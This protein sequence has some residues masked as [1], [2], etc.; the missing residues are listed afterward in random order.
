[1]KLNMKIC[2]SAYKVVSAKLHYSCLAE[3]PV[4]AAIAAGFP[5]K[6]LVKL[7]FSPSYKF[8]LN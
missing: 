3:R 4:F 7:F 1:M 6:S 8:L 5:H 2:N